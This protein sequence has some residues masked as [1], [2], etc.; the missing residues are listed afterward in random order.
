MSSTAAHY[1]GPASL[2]SDYAI[3]SRYA[4]HYP[5]GIEAQDRIESDSDYEGGEDVPE[6]T[7]ST[8]Q[9]RRSSM[10]ST[11]RRPNRPTTYSNPH[12]HH[13]NNISMP[14]PAASENTP[15]LNP[16]V[17]RID[18]QFESTSRH[19]GNMI[20]FWE[21][22]RILTRYALPVFGFVV[23]SFSLHTPI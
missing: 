11:Q 21:E 2:P 14:G 16:A 12:P 19:A 7:S 8:S 15:L 13:F 17:P 9:I 18:E 5:D 23:L 4:G 1:Q 20:I 10:P 6:R 22:L 3:V